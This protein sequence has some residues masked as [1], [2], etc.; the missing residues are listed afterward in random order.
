MS[1]VLFPV[2]NWCE[3]TVIQQPQREESHL[4]RQTYRES[5]EDVTIW[6]K[7]QSNICLPEK[8]KQN[9]AWLDMIAQMGCMGGASDL[10]PSTP[11]IT[12]L[13]SLDS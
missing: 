11:S 8:K 13:S 9:L 1:I 3:K 12:A 4:H 7:P 5:K 6:L 2:G 10:S